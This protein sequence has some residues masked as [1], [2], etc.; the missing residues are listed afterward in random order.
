MQVASFLCIGAATAAFTPAAASSFQDLD[1][2]A[3]G[4]LSL[5]EF[6]QAGGGRSYDA[7]SALDQNQDGA[8]SPAEFAAQAQ[9]APAAAGPQQQSSP[10]VVHR[11]GHGEEGVGSQQQQQNQNQKYQN[12]QQKGQ[13]NIFG[14]LDVNADSRISK[15]EWSIDWHSVPDPEG[16]WA[17]EDKDGDGYI[18]WFVVASRRC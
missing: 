18:S 2:N 13:P 17:A 12:Q 14:M 6:A 8:I 3:D 7:W 10:G 15:R 1:T 4:Q 5:Q 16:L 11:A 9:K